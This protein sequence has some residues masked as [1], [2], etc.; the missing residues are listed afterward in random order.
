MGQSAWTLQKHTAA[1]LVMPE[2]RLEPLNGTGVK[3]CFTAQLGLKLR[4][5]YA[6]KVKLNSPLA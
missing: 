2:M 1:Q 4:C 6:T 3:L 5:P